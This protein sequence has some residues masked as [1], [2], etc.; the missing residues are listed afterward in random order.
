[1]Y[2][3]RGKVYG[4]NDRRDFGMRGGGAEEIIMGRSLCVLG[5]EFS[6][7]EQGFQCRPAKEKV[8]GVTPFTSN[9]AKNAKFKS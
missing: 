2:E 5:I 9:N 6:F 3:A 1:M 8:K 4:T 7:T